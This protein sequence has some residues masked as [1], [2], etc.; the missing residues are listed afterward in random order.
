MRFVR[1]RATGRTLPGCLES[2]GK[3][4]RIKSLE[5]SRMRY[6]QIALSLAVVS[7][8]FF[9]LSIITAPLAIFFAIRSFKAPGSLVGSTRTRSI[10]AIVLASLE[11]IGWGFWCISWGTQ[12]QWLSENTNG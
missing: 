1:L 11:L 6:D 10:I 5:N 9:C 2:G 12:F 7:I 3:K 8:L 4:G